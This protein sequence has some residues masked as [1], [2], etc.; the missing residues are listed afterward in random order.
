MRGSLSLC[1]GDLV[2]GSFAMASAPMDICT[3]KSRSAEMTSDLQFNPKNDSSDTPTVIISP[4]S[5]SNMRKDTVGE[6][7][8]G[9][10]DSRSL[11]FDLTNI[12][13]QTAE[14]MEN[15]ERCLT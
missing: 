5:E 12:N 10:Q 2:S 13:C 7:K 6:E 9:S 3:K 8:S 14:L 11:M 15:M 4:A 1:E